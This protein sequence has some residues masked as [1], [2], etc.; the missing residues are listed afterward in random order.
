MEE[1]LALLFQKLASDVHQGKI[2]VWV[3]QA[4]Q[5]LCKLGWIVLVIKLQ[6]YQEAVL[7]LALDITR[8]GKGVCSYPPAL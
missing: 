7:I 1:I 6:F 8:V 5:K 3:H 4:H 2:L